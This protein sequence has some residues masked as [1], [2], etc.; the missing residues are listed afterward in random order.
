MSTPSNPHAPTSQQLHANGPWLTH[1]RT[2]SRDRSPSPTL[3]ASRQNRSRQ[4]TGTGDFS[5]GDDL[6]RTIS[7]GYQ[8]IQKRTLTKWI[9]VQLDKVGDSITNI[10]TDLRDGRKLLSLLSVVAKEPAPKPEKRTTRIHQISNINQL[11]SFLEKQTGP[12][13]LPDIGSEAIVNGDLKNTLVLTYF[14]ML[15][16]QIQLILTDEDGAFVKAMPKIDRNSTDLS[17]E[18]SSPLPSL[19]SALTGKRSSRSV[20]TGEKAQSSSSSEA[21]MALLYWVRLQLEDYVAVHILPEIQDFSRSWRTGIAFCLLIHRHDPSLLPDILTDHINR[22]T[23]ERQV[24]FD[25]LNTAFELATTHMNIPRYLEPEDLTDVDYPHEPSVMLYVSAYYSSMSKQQRDDPSK[26]EARANE[27][28]RAI[29]QVFGHVQPMSLN[30]QLP[31]LTLE[32]STPI[33]PPDKLPSAKESPSLPVDVPEISVV[34][35]NTLTTAHLAMADQL[36]RLDDLWKSIRP[37]QET[38]NLHPLDG[39]LAQAQSYCQAVTMATEETY[40]LGEAIQVA[41]PPVELSTAYQSLV[42]L[43]QDKQRDSTAFERGVSFL[44]ITQAMIDELELVHQMM[45]DNQQSIT[46]QAIRHLEER[47]AMVSAT[48]DAVKEEYSSLLG[49]DDGEDDEKEYYRRTEDEQRFFDHLQTVE[50]RYETVQDW[51]DQV[52]VWFVEAERIRKWIGERID[53]IET[54]NEL[55]PIDPLGQEILLEDDEIIQLH[56]EQEKLKRECERF[57]GNDMTRLRLHVKTLTVAERDRE[58]S[59]ADTSTIEITLTTLNMLNQLMDLLQKRTTVLDLAL[60]RVK[61]EALFGKAV[62]WIVSTDEDMDVFLDGKARWSEK[63]DSYEAG[64]EQVIQTLVSLENRIADFDSGTYSHVLEAYQETEDL[65]ATALPEHLECRQSGFEKAFEDLM[66]RSS[67]SRKVVEQL[68]SVI[69]AVNQFKQLREEGEALRQAMLDSADHCTRSSDDEIFAEKVQAFKE[70][71]AHVITHVGTRVPYPAVPEMSTAMGRRDSYHNQMT[72]E[73]IR[74]TISAHG[75]SLALIA[76]GLDQLLK[77]RHSII[78]LQQ[79]ASL[80]YDEMAKVTQWMEERARALSKTRLDQNEDCRMEEEEVSRLEK[81]RD[82]IAVRLSQMEED[83]LTRLRESVRLLEDEVDASNAVAIDRNALVN[84]IERLDRAHS[85]LQELLAH[86]ASALDI[87]KKRIAW[88]TQWSRTNQWIITIARKL[89]DFTAKKARYDPIKDNVDKPSYANDKENMQAW[90]SLQDKVTEI[91]DRHLQL[92]NDHFQALA[93]CYAEQDS[94]EAMPDS[95]NDRQNE[96][97]ERYEE[98]QHLSSHAADLMT[99]RSTITEFLLRVQDCHHEGEKIRDLIT[100]M[101]RRIMEQDARPLDARVTSFK[102][103]IRRVWQEC[104]KTM[105][106]PVFRG[107]LLLPLQPAEVSNST[108]TRQQIRALLE[109]KQQELQQLEST[110][111]DLLKAYQE[112]DS[113]KSLVSQY[114]QEAA[115]LRHWIEE[116]SERLQHQHIDVAAETIPDL[117]ATN[118]ERRWE[119]QNELCGALE[120]F[121]AGEVKTLHDNIAALIEESIK[122]KKNRTVDVSSAA[123]SLGEVMTSIAQLKQ[124]LS[125]QSVTLE[126]AMRRSV[127]EKK[128]E[129]G[130]GHLETM[131]EQL[132]HFTTKKNQ[133][134]AQDNLSEEHVHIL[135]SD[136]AQLVS[137]RDVFEDTLLPEIQATYEDFIAYFPRLA[138]PMATPDHIEA[139]MEG[140][141]RSSVRFQEQLT[142]RTKELELIQQRSEWEQIVRDALLYLSKEEA[143]IES[144]VEDKARWHP[145]ADMHEN[146]EERLRTEWVG[147]RDRFESYQQS[148]TLP[149]KQRFDALR[150]MATMYNASLV[151]EALAKRME[152]MDGAEKRLDSGL[153]FSNKVVTQR[154]LVASFILRTAQLE[155]S[156]ELIREEFMASKEQAESNTERLE[157]FK[158]GIQDVRENLAGSIPYPVRSIDNTM[159]RLKDETTNSVIK[160]TVETRHRRLDELSSSLQLLLESKERISRRRMSLH[161]YQQQVEACEAWIGSRREL[162]QTHLETDYTKQDALQLKETVSLADSIETAMNAH[163]N[164]FTVLKSTFEKCKAAFDEQLAEE[165]DEALIKEFNAIAPLQ[166][167]LDNSWATLMT[168]AATATKVISAA[169][170]PAQLEERLETLIA[171]IDLL[172]SAMTQTDSADLTDECLAQW[173]KSVDDLEVKSFHGIQSDLEEN[174][175]KIASDKADKLSSQLEKCGE[176]ILAIRSTLAGLY[177]VVNVN[178]LKRTYNEN[179]VL[180]QEK[181]AQLQLLLENALDHCKQ[182]D[183]SNEVRISQQHN[184]GSLSKEI[185]RDMNDSKESYDDVC[186]YHHLIKS[187]GYHGDLQE[188]QALIDKSWQD[189]QNQGLVLTNHITRVATWINCLDKLDQFQANLLATRASLEKSLAAEKGPSLWTGVSKAIEKVNAGLDGMVLVGE[190]EDMQKDTDNY[191]HWKRRQEE[192]SVLSHQLA[193]DLA[194]HQLSWERANLAETFYADIKRLCVLCEDE[195]EALGHLNSLQITFKTEAMEE[196][197]QRNSISL[198]RLHDTYDSC[199]EEVDCLVNQQESNLAT[200]LGQTITELEE[201]TTPLVDLMKTW[202]TNMVFQD[203]CLDLLRETTKHSQQGDVIQ[204][205][206]EDLKSVVSGEP[207]QSDRPSLDLAEIDQLYESLDE[208]VVSF[209][210]DGD[211]LQEKLKNH[212]DG[213]GGPLADG[214]SLRQETIINAWNDLKQLVIDTRARMEEVQKRRQLATKLS[215]AL[216]YVGDMKDRVNALQLTGKCVNTEEEE[217]QKTQ[218]EIDESLGRKTADIDSILATFTDPIQKFVAQRTK[219]TVEIEELRQLIQSKQKQAV[220]EGNVAGFSRLMERLDALLGQLSTAID[221]AAPHNA[222]LVNNKFNKTELQT[223]MRNLVASYKKLGPGITGILNESK[224]EAQKQLFDDNDQV[225]DRLAKAIARWGK[226]QAAAAAR[227]RELQTC[228][229]KLDHEFFTKLAMAKSNPRKQTRHLKETPSASPLKRVSGQPQRQQLSSA[230]SPLPMLG[231]RRMSN[232]GSLGVTDQDNRSASTIRRSQ[233]PTVGAHPSSA[234]PRASGYVP[235]PN[236][237]LDVA[238]GQIVNESPYR[239]KVKM[240]PGEVGK[241]WFGEE[242]PRLVYCRILSSQLVMVRV[243]GGWVELSKFLRDHGLTDG[244]VTPRGDGQNSSS[245][246]CDGAPFQEVHIQT[247]RAVSPSGRVMIRGGGF[248]AAA[249]PSGVNAVNGTSSSLAPTRSSSKSSSSR[250]RS[251]VPTG[252][253]DGDKYVRVDELGNQMMVRMTKAEEG[254]KM[255]IIT[256]KRPA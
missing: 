176:G 130:L 215:E 171:A 213:Q 65:A 144:F 236:S 21:K 103:E 67:F 175:S 57:N 223:L 81:E 216:R 178:R 124:N 202:Y 44:H 247:V 183:D 243:G 60:L 59:P 251:P 126:A 95:M 104:G 132:R 256:K 192:L 70:N 13:A 61:W 201:A 86:R 110:I 140:L 120:Q 63:E 100:K 138:R 249:G 233:T 250:S 147:L 212:V 50:E 73:A 118:L 172:Q 109:R 129:E 199:K 188:S 117:T 2:L 112:A 226:L 231:S 3:S 56:S 194:T 58:L 225:S 136:L 230:V 53:L 143:T 36:E 237:K 198:A 46:D 193:A 229:T 232:N 97:Q 156:A 206:L 54:R 11:F 219:L 184:L 6:G 167:H 76:D 83:D 196:A 29:R 35:K 240:V 155:Q 114:D 170:V 94:N 23:S 149:L 88:E 128:V 99:Q 190:G 145:N 227:E 253:V 15:K 51:V 168:E 244:V 125:H 254:A 55:H 238:L 52:R 62:E 204:S 93:D 107:Q 26:E 157:L 79:R 197:V 131:N 146:D 78:S 191:N 123:R 1:S 211:L 4:S 169:L 150:E 98:L 207:A 5:A 209:T 210:S 19:S 12:G 158:A 218:D 48:I 164:V 41:D 121:E 69:H 234:K 142:S 137:Q 25:L 153:A 85:H 106:F 8:E 252:F 24:C 47:V 186:G 39:S 22:D 49:Q 246:S 214:V 174:Q 96:Q 17:I 87:L 74:S 217:L 40:R 166:S 66:K 38:E 220:E 30:T 222:S 111:D 45:N 42:E 159:G 119:H 32:T 208:S 134:I 195:L 91:G 161:T 165:G 163:E 113:M 16:Y 160:D 115:R 102:E 245:S 173:Q 154:C 89:W 203:D 10:E 148:T 228:I 221:L 18:P 34:S 71:S 205:S 248:G 122:K 151:S 31:L 20:E 33:Q 135:E 82:G 27:R 77:S 187:Q 75:M 182:L 239:L 180:L 37:S 189:V 116:N 181:M 43:Q 72:N 127:W 185:K 179:M 80:A 141:N 90:Q 224:E 9:N 28:K 235:D 241:Y 64:I 108:H 92:T 177:D 200:D 68:L 255:P 139:S 152:E 101:M 84:S 133:W 105:P 14:I 242:S 162:L 7:K